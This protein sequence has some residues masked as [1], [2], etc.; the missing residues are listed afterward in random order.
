MGIAYPMGATEET[1]GRHGEDSS[2]C[3]CTYKL[4]S[5]INDEEMRDDIDWT[6]QNSLLWQL[7]APSGCEGCDEDSDGGGVG[8]SLFRTL[9][10]EWSALSHSQSVGHCGGGVVDTVS[11]RGTQHP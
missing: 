9:L 5:I 1:T 10:Q 3:R 7:L 11:S 4:C 8:E 2:S 6:D